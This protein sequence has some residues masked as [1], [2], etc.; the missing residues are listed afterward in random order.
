MDPTSRMIAWY[1]C[2]DS[3]STVFLLILLFSSLF[4][5]WLFAYRLFE[6]CGSV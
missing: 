3:I 1:F 6:Y 2:N 4:L 5:A